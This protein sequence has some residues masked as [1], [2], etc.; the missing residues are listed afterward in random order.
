MPNP[1]ERLAE[2]KKSMADAEEAALA[3]KTDGL[4]QLVITD[5]KSLQWWVKRLKNYSEAISE[6][7][8]IAKQR[9][10]A[11][12]K[13]AQDEISKIDAE[14]AAAT[15]DAV[16]EYRRI[17]YKYIGEVEEYVKNKIAGMKNKS[18]SAAGITLGY[19]KEADK[20]KVTDEAKLLEWA[21]GTGL[22]TLVNVKETVDMNEVKSLVKETDK[23]DLPEGLTFVEG[24][25]QFFVKGIPVMEKPENENAEEK[26][27]S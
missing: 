9:R 12:Q 26:A 19:K 20:Y 21:K 10:E 11:V 22:E 27:S 1:A 3:P 6:Q 14:A 8:A 15:K 24:I 16:S 2:I 25:E 18:F 5:E 17:Y 4:G 7:L 13:I 23:S